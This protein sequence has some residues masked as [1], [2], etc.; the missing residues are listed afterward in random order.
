MSNYQV[1]GKEAQVGQPRSKRSAKIVNQVE[2]RSPMIRRKDAERL[3]R[4]GR[5][6]WVAEDQLRL[7]FSHPVNQRAAEVAAIGYKLADYK[8]PPLRADGI[9]IAVQSRGAKH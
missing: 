8:A 2:N 9:T 4:L 3:V 1:A 7:V 6:E 5:A